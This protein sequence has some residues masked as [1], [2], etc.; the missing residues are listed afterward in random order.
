MASLINVL[1]TA[2]AKFQK[3]AAAPSAQ[4]H[5]Q[6]QNLIPSWQ[7]A[8]LQC[9]DAGLIPSETV[10]QVI[11][12]ATTEFQ[13]ED[14][15]IKTAF[16]DAEWHATAM[17][18]AMNALHRIPN[19][20]SSSENE[21]VSFVVACGLLK[22]CSDQEGWTSKLIE[23]MIQVAN[24]CVDA[25]EAFI[26]ALRP[27]LGHMDAVVAPKHRGLRDYPILECYALDTMLYLLPIVGYRCIPE[28]DP[29]TVPYRPMASRINALLL[30][31]MNAL[32]HALHIGLCGCN[33]HSV[34]LRFLTPT[35]S[36][37]P[38]YAEIMISILVCVHL[39][40]F[41]YKGVVTTD[42]V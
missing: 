30:R 21:L 11:A 22:L 23:T 25:L 16:Q 19:K 39:H 24:D 8:L 14:G 33:A 40:S 32:H 1:A 5:P 2:I 26:D 28:A 20:A 29:S 35:V 6:P 7:K 38:V 41:M 37:N 12:V 42:L 9:A 34:A 15:F 31:A 13:P 36:A 17:A 27:A 10:A 4:L 18:A 3:S